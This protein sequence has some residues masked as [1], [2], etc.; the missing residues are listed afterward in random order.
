MIGYKLLFLFSICF[1]VFPRFLSFET[2]KTS[3]FLLKC[4]NNKQN[5]KLGKTSDYK[6]CEH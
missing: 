3:L 6:P 4:S 2:E 5:L 1:S